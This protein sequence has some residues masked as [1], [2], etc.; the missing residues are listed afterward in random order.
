MFASYK[1]RI[2]ISVLHGYMNEKDDPSNDC[3]KKA[4]QRSAHYNVTFLTNTDNLDSLTQLG[5]QRRHRSSV[6]GGMR[7][8]KLSVGD[9][10][11]ISQQP[12]FSDAPYLLT[13][14]VMQFRPFFGAA[15][16]CISTLHIFNG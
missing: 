7:S 3:I 6:R 8:A 16:H 13:V 9:P 10:C 2:S 15:G 4:W 14:Q 12:A 11:S 1:S 5:R